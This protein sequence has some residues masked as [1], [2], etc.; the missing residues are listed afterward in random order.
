MVY[1]ICIV[2]IVIIPKQVSNQPGGS[3][4]LGWGM[5]VAYFSCCLLIISVYVRSDHGVR[6]TLHV[7][8]QHFDSTNSSGPR[9]LSWAGEVRVGAATQERGAALP[10]VSPVP[11][12]NLPVL[13]PCKLELP[14]NLR[15]DLT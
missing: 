13:G 4:V 8:I 11:H 5:M 1:R 10:S 14:T 7:S 9:L 15:G 3:R 12:I 2:L 6:N